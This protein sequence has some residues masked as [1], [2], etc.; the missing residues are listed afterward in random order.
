MQRRFA[1]DNFAQ[2]LQTFLNEI[3]RVIHRNAQ[4]AR[5]FGF[6]FFAVIKHR[7]GAFF[8]FAQL[9]QRFTQRDAIFN[10]CRKQGQR[11]IAFVE[12][13]QF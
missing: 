8:L 6:G 4:L 1:F 12:Q 10:R 11:I 13:A 3:G 2:L 7:N 9:R 5:D